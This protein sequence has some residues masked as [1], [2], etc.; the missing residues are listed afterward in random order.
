MRG[1]IRSC[2]MPIGGI[3]GAN[4]LHATG[5]GRGLILIGTTQVSVPLVY[6]VP[7]LERTLLSIS[8]LA[9][10][11]L[12]TTFTSVSSSNPISI[13][14]IQD[15]KSGAT[16]TSVPCVRGLYSIPAPATAGAT[17]AIFQSDIA[18]TT[19]MPPLRGLLASTSGK[20][21]TNTFVGDTSLDS[22]VHN[23]LG[24][25]SY[26]NNKLT[27][28]LRAVYGPTLGQGHSNCACAACMRA[29]MTQ[30]FNR[31]PPSRPATQPLGR[32]HFDFVPVPC[33][34]TIGDFIGFVIIVDEG[35][36][37]CWTIPVK[38]KSSVC[39]VIIDFVTKAERQ[40]AAKA[41][42]VTC[43]HELSSLRSDGGGENVSEVLA[44][45]CRK[46]GVTQELSAPYCQW[47]NGIAERCVRTVWN[48]AEAMRKHAGMP[49]RYWPYSIQAFAYT[50]SRLAMGD[51]DRS[52][53]E[54]WHSITVP[55]S[56]R[57]AHLR[58]LGCRCYVHI[59]KALRRR[60]DDKA[61]LCIFMGYSDKS[62]AYLAID[63]ETGQLLTAVSVA[64]DE[65]NFPLKTLAIA[66]IVDPRATE[67]EALMM[68][69]GVP[70]TA[71]NPPPAQ[72]PPSPA[73][74]LSLPPPSTPAYQPSLTS[75]TQAPPTT[76][77]THRTLASTYG[78]P[79]VSN[80]F[81]PALEPIPATSTTP[82]DRLVEGTPVEGVADD[83]GSCRDPG[84]PAGYRV[85]SITAHKIFNACDSNGA[86]IAGCKE[87][88]YRVRWTGYN[89]QT[90]EP[91]SSFDVD[92]QHG[93]FNKYKLANAE[94]IAKRRARFPL[95]V[96]DFDYAPTTPAPQQPTP[97]LELPEQAPPPPPTPPAPPAHPRRSERLKP[98]VADDVLALRAL[99][100]QAVEG[101]VASPPP[102]HDD[103]AR[104]NINGAVFPRPS[105]PTAKSRHRIEAQLAPNVGLSRLH[106]GR[107][108]KRIKLLA[109]AAQAPSKCTPQLHL[110]APISYKHALESVNCPAWLRS[111][112]DEM[113]A[114]R[115]F[116]VWVLEPLPPG[117]REISTKWVFRVKR[118]ADGSVAKL[119]SRLTARGFTM[120]EGIDFDETWAP[121]ARMRCFR[122]MMAEASGDATIRTAGWDL[123][124]AF[125]HATMD[126]T[127]YMKQPKGFIDPL[128][129]LHSCR[130]LKAI[131]G[132]PQASRLFYL[133]IKAALTKIGFNPSVAD[134]CLFIRRQGT[135]FM[136]VLIHVDDFAITYNDRALYDE[137]FATM[138]SQ[139]KM[140]D[141]GGGNLE[142]F[143]G[144]EIEHDTDSAIRLHQEPYLAELFSRLHVEGTARSPEAAGSKRRLRPA[145]LP[146][147]DSDARLMAD[148]D[149]K[150][151]VA[152]LFYV[153]RATRPDIAHA[154]SQVAR[155]MDRPGPCH[156][157]AVLRIYRYLQRTRNVALRM[158]ASDMALSVHDCEAFSDADWAGCTE[159]SKSTT[160]WIIRIG[161]STVAWYTKRQGSVAQSSC[162]AEYVAAAAAANEIVW[163]RRLL[164]DFGH[165]G[166]GPT[167]LYCDN[168]AAT[169][170]ARHSGRFDATKHIGLRLHVLR[171]YQENKVVDVTWLPATDMI[172]DIMTKNTEPQLFRRLASIV[173]G[174]TI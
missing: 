170:L 154:V 68:Q 19:A 55:L 44:A 8:A 24:H 123:T 166:T 14:K 103:H 142:R 167:K 165:G 45:W 48:G 112:D 74:A 127:V 56:K 141:F 159:T 28:R 134:E 160:G 104:V 117:A 40:F 139:F 25:V 102:D 42:G 119:K 157:E 5:I 76:P 13:M 156:R 37:M 172:A 71:T 149:Y 132:T 115:D 92:S 64:F 173:M 34:N 107:I 86:E 171:R 10:V 43:S 51:D 147:S 118:N 54:R 96:R 152:A 124:S 111:M 62:K 9:Q 32:L 158:S 121:T 85:G 155:F 6:Y 140:T 162:E 97:I 148:F 120:R 20:F 3:S 66:G 75:P 130:L 18:S 7:G 108:R 136:K 61:R 79:S 169:V 109:L 57:L 12:S 15:D 89:E 84:L 11:G 69:V 145:D 35:S 2:N 26:G 88:R 29:K 36:D 41:G 63:I 143:L 58:T 146:L 78:L 174:E 70:A 22:L 110:K 30:T 39:Q 144:I 49:A 131:Y 125:L 116:G 129:P 153:A 135:S 80:L 60:L 23:R 93:L 46:R 95:Q 50:R 114:M 21:M 106:R 67:F 163:W 33:V 150:G 31:S 100:A 81:P 126:K 83:V 133:T 47:Q 98:P 122:L 38:S 73:Q 77:A 27:A 105:T 168:K 164:S 1:Y 72:T 90:W 17:A 59:P 53:V 82:P 99:L 161:G 4:A 65:T 94:Q 137:V 52:P 151:A 138:Q 128:H 113:A 101:I 91:A 16:L 87:D